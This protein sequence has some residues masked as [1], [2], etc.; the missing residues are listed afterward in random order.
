MKIKASHRWMYEY[1]LIHVARIWER[2]RIAQPF[3]EM[4]Q[5]NI[6]SAEEA[7]P[8]IATTIFANDIIQGFLNASEKVKSDDYWG[9]N[10]KETMSDWFIESL[11]E[12]IINEGYLED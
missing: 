12:G 1:I 9:K 3:Q 2:T 6:V 7:I 10:T 8:D 5:D 4:P 11:A